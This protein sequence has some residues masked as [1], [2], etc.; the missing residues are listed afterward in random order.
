MILSLTRQWRLAIPAIGSSKWLGGVNYTQNLVKALTSLPVHDRPSVSFVIR[1][2]NLQEFSLFESA[3]RLAE[4]VIYVGS[5][6]GV[7]LAIA[8]RDGVTLAGD[9]EVFRRS[10]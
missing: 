1:D 10:A 9:S 7:A 3:A 6:P 5:Q 4:E 8:G 2:A